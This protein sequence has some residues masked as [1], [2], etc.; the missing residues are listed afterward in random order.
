MRV[1]L[2]REFGGKSLLEAGRS[3]VSHPYSLQVEDKLSHI[4]MKLKVYSYDKKDSGL[5]W[6][7][8][9]EGY[10]I[11]DGIKCR[12]INFVLKLPQSSSSIWLPEH[13]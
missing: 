12:I 2:H 8:K 11:E 4:N 10:N 13:Y 1:A 5:G 7:Q 3:L 6:W 9:A